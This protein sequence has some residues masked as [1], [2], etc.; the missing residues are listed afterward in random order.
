M[1]T[2]TI[3]ILSVSLLFFISGVVTVTRAQTDRAPEATLGSAITYQGYLTDN[4]APANGIYDFQFRLFDSATG[5][6]QAG[7]TVTVEDVTVTNGL[8]IAQIDFGTAVWQGQARYLDVGVRLGSS[9]GAYDPFG[10]RQAVTSVPT[11]EYSRTTGSVAWG[12]ITGIPAG[13]ADGTDNVAN[14]IAWS[15]ITGMPAGFADGTDDGGGAEWGST[16]SGNGTGLTLTSNN[17]TALNVT[18][19]SST[20]YAARFY[21]NHSDGA[22]IYAASRGDADS[23]YDI[24]LGGSDGIITSDPSV[25]GSDLRFSAL[26]DLDLVVGNDA[27]IQAGSDLDLMGGV[28]LTADFANDIRLWSAQDIEISAGYNT[29]NNT[30]I[31]IENSGT[32]G[33]ISI[34]SG[35]NL[36][37]NAGDDIDLES[38]DNV[39]L[40]AFD[41]VTVLIDDDSDSS[42]EYFRIYHHSTSSSNILFEVN[43]SGVRYAGS[44]T[45]IANTKSGL[46]EVQMVESTESRIEDFG[47]GELSNGVGSVTIDPVFAELANTRDAYQVFVTPLDDCALYVAEK[48]ADSFVVKALNGAGCSI[49][50]DYRI[51][52]KRIG[53]EDMRLNQVEASPIEANDDQ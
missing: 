50:F 13:F 7:A 46:R 51:V 5:G 38:R 14:T 47:M 16:L 9:T 24:V 22:G 15:N 20:G 6:S 8:F 2:K 19:T 44:T 12:N 45:R 32:T 11:A 33:D 34:N 52:A 49:Q 42:S 10:T 18:G 4:N 28:R 48:N 41:N 27:T 53:Q 30:S 36:Y 29:S 37:V 25:T 23:D 40:A 21:N 3:V 35:D 39:D 43:E 31:K 26:G 1:N 17:S